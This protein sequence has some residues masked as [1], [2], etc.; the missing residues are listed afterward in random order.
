MCEPSSFHCLVTRNHYQINVSSVGQSYL[1]FFSFLGG[2]V[3]WIEACFDNPGLLRA[4]NFWPLEKK[5]LRMSSFSR[6][7]QSFC[8][9]HANKLHEDGISSLA[10]Q[11]ALLFTA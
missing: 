2:G 10:P 6:I 3:G 11:G 7:L 9:F 4:F 8:V 1:F 5:S